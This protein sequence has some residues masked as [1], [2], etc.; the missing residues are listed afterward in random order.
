MLGPCYGTDHLGMI[1]AIFRFDPLG[2]RDP[3]CTQACMLT[4]TLLGKAKRKPQTF[5]LPDTEIY[6]IVGD[7]YDKSREGQMY[8][9]DIYL[10][11][12]FACLSG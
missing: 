10:S 1:L 8:I 5:Q 4:N 11:L 6:V 7:H 3:R 12:S 2:N 9:N